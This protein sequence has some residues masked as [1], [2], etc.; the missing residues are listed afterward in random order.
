MKVAIIGGGGFLGRYLVD[1][2]FD[3]GHEVVVFD[4][5]FNGCS[6]S[7]FYFLDIVEDLAV[8]EKGLQGVDVLY[9]KAGLLGDPNISVSCLSSNDYFRTNV[10]GLINVLDVVKKSSVKKIVFDSSISV[11]GY[12]SANDVADENYVGFPSNFYGCTKI[13]AE[14]L[15]YAFHKET[16]VSVNILRYPRVRD[17]QSRDVINIFLNRIKDDKKIVINRKEK[18]VEFVHVSDVTDASLLLLN[19]DVSWSCFNVSGSASVYLSYLA[20]LCMD[21]SG[22]KIEVSYSE[23]QSPAIES[24]FC[25]VSGQSAFDVLGYKSKVSLKDMLK[26]TYDHIIGK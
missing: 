24:D 7:T 15:L 5:V 16:N 1:A 26:E 23:E 25:N 14:K 13:I 22:K 9:Y 10:E 4:K 17:W 2:L 6:Q 12:I 21:I 3:N 18:Q 19:Q 8:L 20:D 11:Y